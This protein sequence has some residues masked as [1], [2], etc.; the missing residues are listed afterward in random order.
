[1]NVVHGYFEMGLVANVAI[2]VIRRPECI[3]SA[4]VLVGYAET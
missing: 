2:E 3:C 1:M 4:E